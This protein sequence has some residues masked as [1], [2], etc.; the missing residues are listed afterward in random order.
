MGIPL[1]IL[2]SEFNRVIKIPYLSILTLIVLLKHRPKILIVQNPSAFLTMLSIG[3]KQILRY[4]LIVDAHNAGVYPFEEKHKKYRVIFPLFHRWADKTIVTNEL[5]SSIVLSNGGRPIIL[6]DKLPSFNLHEI[7]KTKNT[8]FI[9]TFICSYAS[10]EPYMEVIEASS[11]LPSDTCIKVTGNFRGKLE[12]EKIDEVREHIEFTGYLS[13]HDYFMLLNASD[14]IMDLTTFNDCLVCGA[15]EA[16]SLGV[17]MILSDTP[18]N[19]SWF[20]KGA[21][22]SGSKRDSIAAAILE[23]KERHK[24]LKKDVALCKETIIERWGNLYSH[25]IS[26]VDLK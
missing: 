7:K 23:A 4:Y 26:G 19:R 15:Y 2:N 10:D 8:K 21:I 22:Y 12:Q 5:L 6:P 20:S 16:V 14:V 9:V 25:F 11:L 17:P 1:I 24:E 18:V 13:E 3:L